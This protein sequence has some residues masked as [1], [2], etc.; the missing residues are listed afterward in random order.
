MDQKTI[1]EKLAEHEELIGRLYGEFAR[2]SPQDEQVWQQCA[3]EEFRHAQWVRAMFDLMGKGQLGFAERFNLA[4][5]NTSLKYINSQIERARAG[6]FKPV[7]AVSVALSIE[8]SLLEH[9]YFE[10]IDGDSEKARKI[11]KKLAAETEFHRARIRKIRNGNT[12]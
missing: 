3:E 8:D 7:E 5:L 6:R 10:I 9:R 12:G 11:K 2:L 1:I 4:A